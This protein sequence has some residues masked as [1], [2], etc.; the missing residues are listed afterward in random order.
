[1]NLLLKDLVALLLFYIYLFF[2]ELKL[3]GVAPE[4]CIKYPKIN[5]NNHLDDELSAGHTHLF[6]MN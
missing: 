4:K 6:L 2:K 1:M 5:K 3:M